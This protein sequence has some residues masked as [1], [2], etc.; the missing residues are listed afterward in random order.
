M[1]F[2][3]PEN[4]FQHWVMSEEETLQ[5]AILTI[6]QK[7]CIQNQVADLAH[8]RISLT[9]DPTNIQ[10]TVQRDAELKGQITALQYLIDLS[11]AAEKQRAN[12]SGEL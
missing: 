11:N 8:E 9:I 5:G 3:S 4:Q 12:P 1:A 7:Q 6:T 10:L 2:L